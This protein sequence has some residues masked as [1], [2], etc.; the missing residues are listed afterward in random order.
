MKTKNNKIKVITVDD[1]SVVRDGIKSMF[2]ENQRIQIVGE[3]GNS[4]AIYNLIPEFPEAIVLMDISLGNENGV[5]LTRNIV[6]QFPE[7]AVIILSMFLDSETVL[8]AIE[9]GA[10]GY[11]SKNC[12]KAE[13]EN[14]ILTVSEGNSFFS[15][16][17]SELLLLNLMNKR[18]IEEKNE[19]EKPCVDCLSSREIEILQLFAKGH[20]NQEIS[21]LLFISIRTVE[22]HKTH[23]LQKLNF[24]SQVD[25][26]KF[27]IRNGLADLD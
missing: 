15:R 6:A 25:L 16:E 1:H 21:E 5:E 20:T 14:A 8:L 22:T 13:I 7:I 27:A 26:V 2:A 3:A 10:K 18:K 11:L 4:T 19:S 9:A 12:G 23:I 24:K 17:I